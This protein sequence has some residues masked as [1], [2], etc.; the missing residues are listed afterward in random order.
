MLFMYPD[1]PFYSKK[2]MSYTRS[3][4]KSATQEALREAIRI[5]TLLVSSG[6]RNDKSNASLEDHLK[7]CG[8]PKEDIVGIEHLILEDPM[9]TLERRN[10]HVRVVLMEQENQKRM[11]NNDCGKLAQ[12]S[13]IL[14]KRPASQA[15]SRAAMAA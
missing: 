10:N 13:F 2:N 12:L 5:K 6:R 9:R 3:D 4:R 7:M 8:V 11:G 15:R 14:T 1:D